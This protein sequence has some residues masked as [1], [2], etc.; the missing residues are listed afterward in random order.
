MATRA[1]Q[2]TII[3][4]QVTKVLVSSVENTKLTK[5]VQVEATGGTLE[6]HGIN[7]LVSGQNGSYRELQQLIRVEYDSKGVEV[8]AWL[9]API[10]KDHVESTPQADLLT[11]LRCSRCFIPCI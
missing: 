2:I 7:V 11:K 6:Q 3:E 5:I 8:E 10:L 4:G 9:E 1:E